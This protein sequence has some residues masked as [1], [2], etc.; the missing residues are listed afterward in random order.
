MNEI[1]LAGGCFWGI[2]NYLRQ[3]SGVTKTAVG[4]AG[5]DIST[6]T[7][8]QVCTGTTNHAEA[9]QVIWDE[10]IVNLDTI[11]RVFF[12][13]HDPTTKN[14]Q[15]N[16]TGTQYRS[17]VFYKHPAHADII[18]ARID[19]MT[20]SGIWDMPIVTQVIPYTTFVPAESYHQDYLVK[21][22]QGYNCHF[23]R[24]DWDLA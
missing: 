2:Q 23:P 15:G 21:N 9:V 10:N 1:I 11:L 20:E 18:H 5:G 13:I 3:I 17:A 12:Q 19:K 6:A 14:R 7:Y 8:D 24:P 4:Y 22:P 16:D